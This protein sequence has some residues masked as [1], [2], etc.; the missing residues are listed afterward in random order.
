MFDLFVSVSLQTTY[1]MYDYLKRTKMK[2]Q[3]T[4]QKHIAFTYI[5]MVSGMNP[6]S[7]KNTAKQFSGNDC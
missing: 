5:S 6:D 7:L 2:Q 1:H 4:L 3:H